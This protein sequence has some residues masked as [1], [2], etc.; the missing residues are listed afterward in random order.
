MNV[1]I[2]KTWII[3][4]L[5]RSFYWFLN[6]EDEPLCELSSLAFLNCENIWEKIHLLEF[7]VKLLSGSPCSYWFIGW[8]LYSYW[9]IVPALILFSSFVKASW[10]AAEKLRIFC[11]ELDNVFPVHRSLL[12]CKWGHFKAALENFI[13]WFWIYFQ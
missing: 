11:T 10:R 5:N 1:N 8:T 7:A 9:S 4:G 13:Q 12:E 2:L 6:F 3:W